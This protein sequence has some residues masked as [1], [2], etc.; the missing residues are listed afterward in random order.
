[1]PLALLDAIAGIDGAYT[2]LSWFGDGIFWLFSPTRRSKVRA[3]WAER[4]R[5]FKYGQVI[6]WL[7]ALFIFVVSILFVVAAWVV[8]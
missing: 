4:G 2:L 7:V 5:L 6:S 8:R 3:R 1:M